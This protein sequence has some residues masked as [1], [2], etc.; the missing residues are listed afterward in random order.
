M[1]QFCTCVLDSLVLWLCSYV[2]FFLPLASIRVLAPIHCVQLAR[3]SNLCGIPYAKDNL[4]KR[5]KD[6]TWSL[7]HL[8]RS[9]DTK[10]CG[11]PQQGRRLFEAKPRE[12]KLKCFVFFTF[13]NLFF[14][15]LTKSSCYNIH[16]W[17]CSCINSAN[18]KRSAR[19][20]LFPCSIYY[21][22]WIN[23][24]IRDSNFS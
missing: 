21:R 8:R 17:Y 2:R 15:S 7:D 23:N 9:R 19:I 5:T 24:L 13:C 12:T 14:L 10:S 11:T 3:V 22:F 1:L 4:R 18:K 6:S 16:L 20:S